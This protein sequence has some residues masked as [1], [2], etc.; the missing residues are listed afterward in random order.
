MKT[1]LWVKGNTTPSVLRTS[2]PNTT[3]KSIYAESVCVNVGFGGELH[4]ANTL[5]NENGTVGEAQSRF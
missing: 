5:P 4:R 3:I 2:P 1:G